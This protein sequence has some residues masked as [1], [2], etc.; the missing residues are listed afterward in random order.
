MR[1]LGPAARRFL[2]FTFLNT[3][4]WQT[5]VGS[6]LVLH[7]RALGMPPGTVGLMVAI[8]PSTLV[9]SLGMTAWVERLGP[10]R[11]MTA[12]WTARNLLAFPLVLTPWLYAVW[13]SRVACWAL[14]AGV[15]SFCTLRS[16][17]CTGWFPWLHEIIPATERGRYFSSEII[18]VQ[19][20]NIG[21]G[22]A[23][24]V[25]L[26]RNP[27]LWKFAALAGLGITAG[28]TSISLMRRIP[29]GGPGVSRRPH[30]ALLDLR[31]V[32]RDRAFLSF[33]LWTSLGYF[34][35]V[36]QG[37]L[38]VLSMRDY[39]HIAPAW[40]ML[41]TS[42]GSAAAMLAGPWWG[43]LAD[44]HGSG[45]VQVLSGTAMA[46]ALAA[47]AC[48]REPAALPLVMPIFA[49]CVA[50]YSG[51]FVAASRGMLQRMRPRLRAG[52]SAVWQSLT[53]VAMGSSSVLIGLVIQRVGDPAFTILPLAYAV[54]MVVAVLRYATLP[55]ESLALASE[56]RAQFN[57]A[58]PFISILL[59]CRYVLDPPELQAEP[60]TP[61]R[62]R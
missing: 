23:T 16:L 5:L 30:R 59:A 46:L 25:F 1:L 34:V 56:L 17:T 60:P 31:L 36:G 20:V 10:R 50:S 26:G 37:T 4:S 58:Q 55:E 43:R 28:L 32:G 53:A 52:Y 62:G 61:A 57:P 45:P 29:G 13:G 11:L 2:I 19:V 21:I 33:V 14:F 9:L 47:F 44:R 42:A 41:T 3:V 15:L 38:I 54:L 48:L 27:A 51:F 24:F 7:A 12:G 6:V 35:T 22:L 49:L 39:L 40:I 18:L 8:M